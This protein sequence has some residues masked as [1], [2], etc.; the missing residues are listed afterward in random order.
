MSYTRNKR[1]LKNTLKYGVRRNYNKGSLRNRGKRT[2]KNIGG[3]K[4]FS[5][6]RG[7]LPPGLS[8]K[9]KFLQSDSIEQIEVKLR[10]MYDDQT[11]DNIRRFMVNKWLIYLTTDTPHITLERKSQVSEKVVK[12]NTDKLNREMTEMARNSRIV[13]AAMARPIRRSRSPGASARSR[14][15]PKSSPK[16]SPRSPTASEIDAQLAE[17]EA[18]MRKDGEDV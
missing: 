9:N 13:S 1:A 14:S 17:F 6:C 4:F 16:S 12:E 18:Q 8:S 15:S 10:R 7:C 11:P 3:G 5:K 2:M